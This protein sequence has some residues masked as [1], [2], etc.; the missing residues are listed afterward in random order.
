MHRA[1]PYRHRL[2][3]REC[4]LVE[5]DDDAIRIAERED[6]IMR[7]R[8]EVDHE[9]RAFRAG[10]Q[11]HIIDARGT[12]AGCYADAGH[13]RERRPC[14]PLPDSAPVQPAHIT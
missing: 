10:P 7:R 9:T 1:L 3:R 13:A 8:A 11:A 14:S 6:R 2:A 5:I 12:G 4:R